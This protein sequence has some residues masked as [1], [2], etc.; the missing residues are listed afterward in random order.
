[1]RPA[2]WAPSAEGGGALHATELGDAVHRLLERVDLARPVAPGDLDESERAE[3]WALLDRSLDAL[4]DVMAP[5]GFNA[6]INIGRVAGAG[7]ED[8][9]HLHVVPRWN[10]DTNFMSVVGEIRIV[11]QAMTQLYDELVRVAAQVS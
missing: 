3:M 5:H 11:P 1:M 8:H 7:V 6:G 10:G 9:I 2:A 4:T